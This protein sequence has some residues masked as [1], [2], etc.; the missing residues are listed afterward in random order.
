M[1]WLAGTPPLELPELL[2]DPPE[3]PPEVLPELL[4]ELPELLPELPD[5]LPELLPELPGPL[6]ELLPPF[7]FGVDALVSPPHPLEVAARP[8]NRRKPQARSAVVDVMVAAPSEPRT[9]TPAAE[10]PR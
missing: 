1:R 10:S 2:L 4:P 3:L 6:P 9:G 8:P 5:P 7:G